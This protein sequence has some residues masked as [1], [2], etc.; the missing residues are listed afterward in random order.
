LPMGCLRL[1][2]SII[3]PTRGADKHRPLISVL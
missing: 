3:P 1:G 2:V